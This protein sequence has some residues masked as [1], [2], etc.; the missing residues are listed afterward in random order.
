MKSIDRS[1]SDINMKTDTLGASRIEI[2][3]DNTDIDTLIEHLKHYHADETIAYDVF[4]LVSCEKRHGIGR[5]GTLEIPTDL[6]SLA[7]TIKKKLKLDFVRFAGNPDLPIIRVAICSGSGSSLMRRFL[8]SGTQ[9]YISG[10]LHYHD[11][12]EAEAAKCG[13][14]DVGHFPSEHLMVKVMADQLQN[15]F[16]AKGIDLRIEA[17]TIEKDPFIVL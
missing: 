1:D 14:I 2:V 11:A 7:L 16:S 4:P 12:R 17:C 13:I 6:K 5:I 9:A 10:D 3:I 8:S 15:E